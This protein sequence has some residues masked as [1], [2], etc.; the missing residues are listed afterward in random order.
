M[1]WGVFL[2]CHMSCDADQILRSHDEQERK[3]SINGF[4]VLGGVKIPTRDAVDGSVRCLESCDRS[5]YFI[6]I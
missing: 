3:F 6:G 4:A 1:R 5:M 2:C